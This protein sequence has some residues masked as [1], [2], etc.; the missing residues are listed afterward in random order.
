MTS[1][2]KFVN[3]TNRKIIYI[4]ADGYF[5]PH[6]LIREV[7]SQYTLI[8]AGSVN[9]DIYDSRFKQVS[10]HRISVP[11]RILCEIVLT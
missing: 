6:P 1:W 9:V 7:P 5:L 2:V 4:S 3:R 10:S 11:P 8:A